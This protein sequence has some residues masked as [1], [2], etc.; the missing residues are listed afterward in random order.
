MAGV[1]A[2]PPA[3]SLHWAGTPSMSCPMGELPSHCQGKD[4]ERRS[5]I[6][7]SSLG[8]GVTRHNVQSSP[9]HRMYP[10]LNLPLAELPGPGLIAM[11]E[12]LHGHSQRNRYIGAAIAGGDTMAGG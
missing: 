6:P 10:L 8:E 12:S 5:I 1:Y 4:T 11:G 9:H 2:G 7:R 3:F